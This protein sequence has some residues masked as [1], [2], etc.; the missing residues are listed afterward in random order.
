VI[1]GASWLNPN[2]PAYRDEDDFHRLV[3]QAISAAAEREVARRALAL[4]SREDGRRAAAERRLA[5]VEAEAT[6]LAEA[7]RAWTPCIMAP[8]GETLSCTGAE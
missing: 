6:S 1:V 5:E 3:N 4:L 2:G 7:A 8:G